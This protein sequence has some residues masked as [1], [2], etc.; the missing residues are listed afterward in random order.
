MTVTIEKWQGAGNAYLLVEADALPFPLTPARAVL[1][2]DPRRGIGAD[3]V[4]ELSAAGDADG[5]MRIV[6]P[7][8]SPSE[9]CGNGTRM[10]MRYLAARGAGRPVDGERDGR[11]DREVR[12][13]TVAGLLVG[14]VGEDRVAV[15]MTP[16][17]L[18]GPQYR[19]TDEPFP[20]VH[21]FV[22]IGNP[23]VVIA[24]DDPRTFPL[25]VEG[26]ILERHAWFPERA[27][28]EVMR[29]RDRHHVEMRVWER[30]VGET[31]A[32]GTGACAVAVA[33]VLSGDA[34]S[35]VEVELPGGALTIDVDPATLDVRMT[36]GAE[37]IATIAL[38]DDLVRLLEA[39]G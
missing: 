13:R 33:A 8:G 39:A 18:A 38:S 1:L 17:E 4:L 14:T 36:G 2:C 7:D 25:E 28:V 22:S 16:A 34:E 29:V 24:V 31:R 27:N 19:P 35:P 9:A 20:Y 12:L 26:P 21:R 37:R 3:G 5:S 23:H 10:V 11:G 30:G 6:N 32:C 15:E